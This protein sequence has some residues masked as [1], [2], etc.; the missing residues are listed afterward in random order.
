VLILRGQPAAGDTVRLEAWYDSLAVRRSNRE[1]SLEPDTDGMIG[2]RYRGRL[3]ADGGYLSDARP[4]VPDGV[5]EVVDLSHALD[6]LFPRLPP[7]GLRV[8]ASWRDPAGLEISRLSDSVADGRDTLLRFR[9]RQARTVDSIQAR[10]DTAPIPAKQTIREEETF[11]WHVKRGLVRTDRRVVVDTDIPGGGTVGRH[12]QS[13][14]EQRITLER[15]SR[16][17]PPGFRNP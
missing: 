15:L 13:R 17:K 5:A 3:T 16:G 8:G 14:V 2:G 12:V 4:F 10:G 9:A 7:R 1:G 6:Q 11:A